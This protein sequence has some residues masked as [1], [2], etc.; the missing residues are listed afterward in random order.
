ML[1]NYQYCFK[2]LNNCFISPV[3]LGGDSPEQLINEGT[4]VIPPCGFFKRVP[5]CLVSFIPLMR[6]SLKPTI[7]RPLSLILRLGLKHTF[8]ADV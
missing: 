3:Y 5:C 2:Y 6:G 1:W 7:A 4:E 8:K